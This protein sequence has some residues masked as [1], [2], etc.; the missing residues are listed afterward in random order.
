MRIKELLNDLGLN[1]EIIGDKILFY[2]VFN[3]EDILTMRQTHKLTVT[4]ID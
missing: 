4:L 1:T 3:K 2:S